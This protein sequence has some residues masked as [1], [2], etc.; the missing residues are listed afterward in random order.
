MIKIFKQVKTLNSSNK[1]GFKFNW[2]FRK[3]VDTGAE[4]PLNPLAHKELFF[5][6]IV[7][8]KI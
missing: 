4:N 3:I 5:D 6:L 8:V 1:P 2:H 7:S